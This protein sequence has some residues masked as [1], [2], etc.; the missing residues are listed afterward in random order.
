MS[1]RKAVPKAVQEQV[2]KEYNHLCSICGEPRP[3]LHHI[4]E[5]RNDHDPLNLLPLCPNCHLSDQHNPTSK[6][7]PEI[8]SLFRKH[9]DPTILT[10]QFLP[11][12]ARL[13]FLDWELAE[14]EDWIGFFNEAAEM[15]HDLVA[16]VEKL[17]MGRYYGNQIQQALKW[18]WSLDSDPSTVTKEKRAIA[19]VAV[20][21]SIVEM[22]RYQP[23]RV[24][25]NSKLKQ[26]GRS[27]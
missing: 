22:L 16:F 20:Y 25:R 12:Y 6:I 18:S 26:H 23:W 13:A 15:A 14:G 21:S 19:R 5:N 10:P 27:S 2:M 1:K 7:A 3:Q 9:K 11:L 17:E 8:L 4:D 24:E